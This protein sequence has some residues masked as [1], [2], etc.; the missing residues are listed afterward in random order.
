MAPRTDLVQDSK[1][2]RVRSLLCAGRRSDSQT[3]VRNSRGGGARD[4]SAGILPYG[5]GECGSGKRGH[6]CQGFGEDEGELLSHCS[7]STMTDAA[8]VA[9]RNCIAT[10]VSFCVLSA[11]STNFEGPQIICNFLCIRVPSV[12]LDRGLQSKGW[13]DTTSVFHDS[14]TKNFP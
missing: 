10:N 9:S 4:G 13:T 6:V 11:E 14:V 7:Q 2:R 5:N 1:V 3:V 12:Q 8:L